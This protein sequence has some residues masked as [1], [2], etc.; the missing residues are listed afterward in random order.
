MPNIDIVKAPEINTSLIS[1][2]LIEIICT[3]IS[4]MFYVILKSVTI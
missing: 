1:A 4:Y 2:V 3:V